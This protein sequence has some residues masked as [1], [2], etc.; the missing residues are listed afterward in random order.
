LVQL[1]K[2]HDKQ[3]IVTTHNPAV[4]DGLDLYDDEATFVVW[5]NAVGET[6]IKRVKPTHRHEGKEPVRMSEAIFNGYIGGLSKIFNTA[7]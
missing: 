4:L 3:T 5:R 1:A 7:L 6:K 2:D